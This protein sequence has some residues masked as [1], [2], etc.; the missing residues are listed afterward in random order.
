MRTSMRCTWCERSN[1]ADKAVNV[2]G[3]VNVCQ[4][5]ITGVRHRE[6]EGYIR[7]CIRHDD[8]WAWGT[9]S[10][11]TVHVFLNINIRH[12]LVETSIPSQ[13]RFPRRQ[14]RVDGH[15]STWCSVAIQGI[16]H[17]LILWRELIGCAW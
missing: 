4:G 16:V 15:Q 9:I 11:L 2:I 1:V 6:S 13:V 10:I 8:D 14:Y 17:A 12:R 5:K 3:Y 7:R